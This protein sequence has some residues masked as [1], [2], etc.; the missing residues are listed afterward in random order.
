MTLSQLM[1]FS[2]TMAEFWLIV[3]VIFMTIFVILIVSENR[4]P[5]STLAWLLLF[6][7]LPGVGFFL[8]IAIGR[9]WRLRS[10]KK[11]K[12]SKKINKELQKILELP[13]KQENAVIKKLRKDT[14]DNRIDK[15]I[16]LLKNNTDSL[17]TENNQITILQNG[18]EKF[19]RLIEDI[20]KAKHFIHLEYFIWQNDSLTK[21]I[22][23]LLIK[24][25]EE[26]VE[27]RLI[28]DPIGWFLFDKR[29][30]SKLKLMKKM[31][32][33][34][35]EVLFFFNTLSPLRF[36]TLNYPLHRKIAIID[37]KIGYTGGMNMGLEYLNG[38][39]R[40]ASWR[41][42]HLR[43]E[44]EAVLALQAFFAQNWNQ[45]T[46][47]NKLFN[48]KYF[49][50]KKLSS[51]KNNSQI[52]NLIACGPDSEWDAIR[53]LF[54]LMVMQAKK[55]VYIQSPY[56]VPDS[57]FFEALKI[58]AL[59]GVDVR[60][61]I[62]GRPDK[63]I[64]YWTAHT[65]FEGLLQAGVKIYHYKEGFLHTKTITMDSEVC[66][67]GSSN[68]DIRSFQ[69]SHEINALIANKKIALELEQDFLN[70]LKKCRRF[71]LKDYAKIGRLKKLRNYFVKLLAPLL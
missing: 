47:S 49:P 65:Y 14:P 68:L 11:I 46:S 52:I 19:P 28:V 51:E 25:K 8:Y 10:N 45:V 57:A 53:Q 21:E 30:L 55:N 35:L 60:L 69:I 29:F 23:E 58:T 50:V 70:D 18:S 38:S 6:W 33:S 31:R 63:K 40:F 16:S 26:G 17:F 36:T 22:T 34:G 9:N 71:T 32:K 15:I 43:I 48:L 59:S 41:D 42:T 27:V 44:G 54:F 2:F 24:K 62:A 61:M 37:G 7:F 4:E 56:F 39:K 67:V 12:A 13:F 1:N 5:A 64:P 66:T 20:K 3:Y